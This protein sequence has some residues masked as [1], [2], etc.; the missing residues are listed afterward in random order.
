[1]RVLRLLEVCTLLLLLL[2]RFNVND[3]QN[4]GFRFSEFILEVCADIHIVWYNIITVIT[5]NSYK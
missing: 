2:T 4:T 3:F 5:K 1:M